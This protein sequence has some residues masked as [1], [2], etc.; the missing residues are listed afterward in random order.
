MAGCVGELVSE[1]VGCFDDVQV[2]QIDVV[3]HGNDVVMHGNDVVMHGNN[4]VMH[5]KFATMW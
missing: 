2:A 3:T 4:V 1:R 5:C